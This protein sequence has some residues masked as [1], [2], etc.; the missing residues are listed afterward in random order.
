MR[1]RAINVFSAYL[2][3]SEKT[4]EK[5]RLLR[6]DSDFLCAEYYKV[7]K[8]CDNDFIKQLNIEC[9]ENAQE[10]AVKV[11]HLNGYSVISMPFRISSYQSLSDEDKKVFWVKEIEKIFHFVLPLMNCKSSKIVDFTNYLNEKYKGESK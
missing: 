6:N 4:K 1:L 2:G 7:V 10:I 3:D 9:D 8:Y 11:E 5:T